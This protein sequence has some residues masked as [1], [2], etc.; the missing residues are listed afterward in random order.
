M[1]ICIN[2]NKISV[3]Q[4]RKRA[5]RKSDKRVILPIQSCAFQPTW[6]T[7]LCICTILRQR[8]THRTVDTCSQDKTS[9]STNWIT[10]MR[11]QTSFLAMD[12]N[13]ASQS[14]TTNTSIAVISLSSQ[15]S[16]K[17]ANLV[18]QRNRQRCWKVE[19]R[20]AHRS[21]S[22]ETN[23]KF[24][25]HKSPKPIKLRKALHLQANK[26]ARTVRQAN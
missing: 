22:R 23:L 2:W 12:L 4:S 9:I 19:I 25:S 1:I 6:S 24:L 11:H 3:C 14:I 5:N 18:Q 13:R 16:K 7:P 8:A 21:A 15:R 20:I 17:K 10:E 26:K